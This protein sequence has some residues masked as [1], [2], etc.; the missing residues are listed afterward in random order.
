MKLRSLIVWKSVRQRRA[1]PTLTI[2]PAEAMWIA[3]E[4]YLWLAD[5][6]RAGVKTNRPSVCVTRVAGG[7]FA[8]RTY[9]REL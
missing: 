3:S 4:A 9:V 2:S 1:K 8:E 5:Q 6:L 7:S